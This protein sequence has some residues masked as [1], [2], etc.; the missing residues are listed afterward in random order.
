MTPE[1]LTAL[2]ARRRGEA[3][4]QAIPMAQEAPGR[5]PAAPVERPSVL[6][7]LGEAAAEQFVPA[8]QETGKAAG[9]ML[10][11]GFNVAETMLSRAPTAGQYSMAALNDVLALV[12]AISAVRYAR[13]APLKGV[14]PPG[15]MR[16]QWIP[17]KKGVE[18]AREVESMSNEDLLTILRPEQAAKEYYQAAEAA[19]A[20]NA[21]VYYAPRVAQSLDAFLTKYTPGVRQKE[22]LIE[23]FPTRYV[24]KTTTKATKPHPKLTGTESVGMT[25]TRSIQQTAEVAP[26]MEQ[27]V[28]ALQGLSEQLKESRSAINPSEW[29]SV[30]RQVQS[31]YSSLKKSGDPRSGDLVPVLEAF[32]EDLMAVKS[33]S[34]ELMLKG[35]QAAHKEWALRDITTAGLKDVKT[36]STSTGVPF[37]RLNANE[38]TKELQLPENR[39]IMSVFTSDEKARM[40][41]T[42]GIV[43]SMQELD[44]GAKATVSSALASIRVGDRMTMRVGEFSGKGVTPNRPHAIDIINMATLL[45]DGEKMIRSVT[46]KGMMSQTGI[47]MLTNFVLSTARAHAQQGQPP[48]SPAAVGGLDI[49]R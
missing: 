30:K 14:T 41:R 26:G 16:G 48:A 40:I 22:K 10:I 20:E 12:P 33:P 42:W 27:S 46:Q 3:G 47:L 5:P 1:E 43:N 45:P 31:L 23:T 4:Q 32:R 44:A 9:R 37:R 39:H 15:A 2:I 7:A 25:S 36:G 24:E 19:A 35:D 17:L 49:N 29:K 34:G 13:F 6:G 18:K 21:E 11:P 28:Q 8:L 38:M